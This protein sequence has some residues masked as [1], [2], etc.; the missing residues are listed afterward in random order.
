MLLRKGDKWSWLGQEEIIRSIIRGIPTGILSPQF[1]IDGQL[2]CVL[3]GS[4]SKA[5][6][7]FNENTSSFSKEKQINMIPVLPKV[8]KNQHGMRRSG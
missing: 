5:H 1:G 2:R 3:A 8:F 6:L 4:Q 7:L